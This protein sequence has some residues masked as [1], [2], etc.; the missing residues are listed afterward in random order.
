M[1]TKPGTTYYVRVGAIGG[2][3][4]VMYSD[5]VAKI[6]CLGR[7]TLNNFFQLAKLQKGLCYFLALIERDWLCNK[8]MSAKRKTFLLFHGV[9]RSRID[10]DWDMLKLLIVF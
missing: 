6:S 7:R 2:N 3:G 9:N 10:N 4:Q 8:G 5:V 1:G